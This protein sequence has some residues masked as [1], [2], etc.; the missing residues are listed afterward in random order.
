MGSID[1]HRHTL[2][3][4]ALPPAQRLREIQR[5]SQRIRVFHYATDREQLAPH[6]GGLSV[7]MVVRGAESFLVGGQRLRLRAGEALLMPPGIEYGSEITQLTESFSAFF[8]QRLCLQLGAAARS[9]S[10]D[11]LEPPSRAF[12]PPIALMPIHADAALR[13]DLRAAREHLEHQAHERAEE[14]L[15]EAALRLMLTTHELKAAEERLALMRAGQRHELLRRLQRAQAYLHDNIARPVDLECLAEVSHVSRFHLLRSFRQAF[16]LTPAQYHAE[17]RLE[18]AAVLLRKK[19]L[20]VSEV[21]HAVGFRSHSAFSR[22]WKRRY[23]YP[24]GNR[25]P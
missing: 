4:E 10:S 22:A 24:P 3:L 1:Y 25:H 21:A 2:R 15:Q 14:L 17:L 5:F 20:P 9:P 18:R 19:Q 13:A 23:G 8:P 6:G 16:G 12:L 11:A 7:K